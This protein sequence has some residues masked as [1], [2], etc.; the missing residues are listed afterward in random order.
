MRGVSNARGWPDVGGGNLSRHHHHLTV[1]R[2]RQAAGDGG[3]R[4]GQAVSTRTDEPA[5]SCPTG[6]DASVTACYRWKRRVFIAKAPNIL[7]TRRVGVNRCPYRA[8]KCSELPRNAFDRGVPMA[9]WPAVGRET[10]VA[11]V[12]GCM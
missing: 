9:A 8:V 3:K 6:P 12:G 5:V 7:Q 10:L 2:P 4:S 11:D 1:R